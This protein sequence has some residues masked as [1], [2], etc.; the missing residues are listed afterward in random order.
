MTHDTESE[1]ANPA[2]QDIFTPVEARIVGC[3]IEKRWTTPNN[4]PLTLNSLVQACNQKSNRNPV[5]RLEV[6]EVG[7]V[8]NKLRDRDLIRASFSTRAERYELKLGSLFQL[9]SQQ[10][11]ALAVLMLRGPQ[12]LGELRINASRMVE[13]DDLPAMQRIL[14]SLISHTPQLVVTLH[15]A[16]GQREE[17]YAHLLCGEVKQEEQPIVA[18][19]QP[20]QGKDRITDL[21]QE[22]QRL[23]AEVELLWRLT[24]LEAQRSAKNQE[25]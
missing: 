2:E 19:S 14:E 12:T 16:P 9:D 13:F 1:N 6:G 24:G 8:V 21:E 7:H 20:D 10:R 15:R 4:Y 11:A 22:V 3:L 25:G 18:L 5:M 23:R 17:R